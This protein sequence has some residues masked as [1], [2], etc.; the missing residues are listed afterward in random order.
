MR[1]DETR[2]NALNSTRLDSTR[3]VGRF[4]FSSCRRWRIQANPYSQTFFPFLSWTWNWELGEGQRKHEQAKP[5]EYRKQWG[6]GLG[7]LRLSLSS[8]F[9]LFLPL[10]LPGL[11]IRNLF[12]QNFGLLKHF[13]QGSNHIKRLLR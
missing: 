11:V 13:A 10:F 1:Q 12:Q 8:S 4:P 7:R 5:M 3:S 2:R 6:L 9:L